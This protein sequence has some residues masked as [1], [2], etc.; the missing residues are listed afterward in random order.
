MRLACEDDTKGRFTS[1]LPAAT[2]SAIITF[3]SSSRTASKVQWAARESCE[4][5]APA[6]HVAGC[7]GS[8]LDDM[9]GNVEVTLY[10][11]RASVPQCMA[12][13]STTAKGNP[14]SEAGRTVAHS[15]RA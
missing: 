15:P 13:P 3:A 1:L 6:G 10:L 12:T 4:L 9:I 2:P 8:Q 14:V 7:C 5:H 11:H